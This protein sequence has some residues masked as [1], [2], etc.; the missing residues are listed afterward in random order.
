MS[1][2]DER[3][4]VVGDQRARDDRL[5]CGSGTSVPLNVDIARQLRRRRAA[6]LRLPLLDCG[7]CGRWHRDPWTGCRPPEGPDDFG[8]STSELW[9]EIA[10]CQ[11]AGW[12]R[13]ELR[14][15]FADPRGLVLPEGVGR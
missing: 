1:T 11:R 15:R 9:A 7:S 6:A 5:G 14:R 10:R 13:W 3:P 12:A 8:L 2:N 4:L